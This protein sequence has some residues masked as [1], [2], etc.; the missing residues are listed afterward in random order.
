[1]QIKSQV[2]NACRALAQE[3]GFYRMNVDELAARAGISKRTL[4]KYFRSKEEIIA[5]TIDDFMEEMGHSADY[6]VQAES[7]PEVM[8]HKLFNQLF[9]RGQ[10]LLNPASLNDLRLHYP[11][12]WKKIDS[13]RQERINTVIQ[14]WL[15][16][17]DKQVTNSIDPRILTASTMACIQAVLN[18]DFIISNGFT[19]EF[20]AQHL[21]R[22]LSAALK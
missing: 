7:N 1:M 17:S 13:F 2:L 11:D 5:A 22:F 8:L 3:K 16:Q 20:T 19:F 9:T 21:S 10:F 18:P 6:L 4:Y 12:M 15:K 14:H